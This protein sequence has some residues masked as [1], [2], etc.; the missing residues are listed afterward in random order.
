MRVRLIAVF[1]A[2]S[3]NAAVALAQAPATSGP[4]ILAEVEKTYAAQLLPTA[5]RPPMTI[6]QADSFAASVKYFLAAA[7]ADAPR[8][9]AIDAGT[10]LRLRQDKA[11]LLNWV[12]RDVPSRLDQAVSETRRLLEN[13]VATHTD[14]VKF[15][16][17]ID[18]KDT[19]KV[20]NNFANPANVE[21]REVAIRE[22]RLQLNTL[23]RLDE[24]LG[25]KSDWVE[26]R[27]QFE[28]LA[29]TFHEKLALAGALVVPPKD[30]GDAD[31]KKIADAT[32]KDPQYGATEWKRLLVNFPEAE[33]HL[34]GL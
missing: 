1:F 12:G 30:I 22:A 10:D 28:A 26:R 33:E 31:L 29:T 23:V 18:M 24:V 19:D 15:A 20:R 34:L 27:A 9:E 6:E 11:R 7:K 13:S 25:V 21:L 4:A 32:L 5:L 3:L 8:I 2:T 16:A 14:F 17:N